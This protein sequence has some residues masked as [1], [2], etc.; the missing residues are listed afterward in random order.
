MFYALQ[1]L[2]ET[3]HSKA[4]RLLGN[5]LTPPLPGYFAVFPTTTFEPKRYTCSEDSDVVDPLAAQMII[6]SV[7]NIL[8]DIGLYC[9]FNFDS[10]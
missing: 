8:S 10:I 4:L 5:S 6:S 1:T 7:V 2:D 3:L 9:I